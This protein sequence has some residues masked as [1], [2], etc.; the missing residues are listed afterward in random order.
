MELDRHYQGYWRRLQLREQ[1]QGRRAPCL[2][3]YHSSELNT[4]ERLIFDR[5]R[6]A[7]RLLDYGAG[8]GRL[9]RKILDAGFAG[10]YETLDPSEEFPHDYRKLSQVEGRFDAVLCLEVVEH[11]PLSAFE[12]VVGGLCD[13]LEP[14]GVFVLSTPNP[15][16]VVPMWARD[17]GHIQ[18]YPLGDLISYFLSREFSVDPFRVR[19]VPAHPSLGQRA[20]LFTQRVLCYLLAVDYADGLLVVGTKT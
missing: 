2:S 8:D 1:A 5:V 20:R 10:R 9:K 13:R 4:A 14:G 19:L 11:L 3:W 12:D 6:H 15:L 18:Q 16:C 17:S 7:K